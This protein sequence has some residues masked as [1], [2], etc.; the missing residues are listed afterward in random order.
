MGF[1]DELDAIFEKLPDERSTH[2]VSATFANEVRSLA[3]RVQK[4]AAHVEGTRLGA[5]NA[6]IAHV[7]HVVEARQKVDALVNLL[8]SDPD[9]QTLA[10]AR[11][12]R[13]VAE[14]ADRL[15]EAG[16]AASSLS[17]EMDQ[18]ARNRALA[19]FKRGDLRILVATD[20]AARGIDVPDIARVV[21]I[22]VP[23]DVDTYVHRSGRTGRAGRQGTS[24][25]LVSPSLREQTSR[26][27]RRA[28]LMAR[29]EPI[30]TAA[31]IRQAIDDR[32]F[33][34]LT[35]APPEGT[36]ELDPRTLAL[37]QRIVDSGDPVR[38][39]SLLLG[40]ARGAGIEPRDVRAL[41]A[42]AP[43]GRE[44]A[45][46]DREAPP[47]QRGDGG[48][49]RDDG[50]GRGG[51]RG[52][53]GGYVPFRVTWGQ[54]QGADARRLMALICRRGDIRGSDVGAIQVESS[55]SIVEVGAAVA[56]DF[57]RAAG[58]PDPRD[59]R[60]FIVR[61]DGGKHHPGAHPGHGPRGPRE[62]SHETSTEDRGPR[63]NDADR[64]AADARPPH[65][66]GPRSKP[67]HDVPEDAPSAGAQP[68]HPKGPRSKPKHDVPEDAPSAGARPPHPKGPRSKPKHETPVLRARPGLHPPRERSKY[69]QTA[70][71][72]KRPHA[73]PAP[74]TDGPRDHR[75]APAQGHGP[76]PRKKR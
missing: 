40:R 53:G 76:P 15:A 71:G 29:F 46:R 75:A 60:V 19:A 1:R 39:I 32:V 22:D 23:T 25:L 6:D 64:P 9:A 50:G 30:P 58:A 43:A 26:L 49:R 8:L 62:P 70:H 65:P 66:K 38:I 69:Q 24:S 11:T 27:L 42:H 10:F 31:D 44:R 52:D 7:V 41:P 73:R 55:F 21:H 35:A 20:V 13:D 33:Q 12:R 3:D 28:G 36:P 67:K 57:A 18:A 34:Q 48:G 54:R 37:A 45:T 74:R 14:I 51:R 5:V 61:E 2:L 47:P 4:N 56:A 59:P 16:F 63:A 68:P 72:T 17:G